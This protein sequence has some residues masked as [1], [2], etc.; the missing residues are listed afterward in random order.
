MQPFIERRAAP[1]KYKLDLYLF[2]F[3]IYM[4]IF[5]LSSEVEATR[6]LFGKLNECFDVLSFV[7]V[8]PEVNSFIDMSMMSN[9]EM[10]EVT[11]EVDGGKYC[12]ANRY[13]QSLHMQSQVSS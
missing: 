7:G 1:F 4:L 9:E 13:T 11:C 6:C 10:V 3:A 12:R 5:S 8:P 2:L